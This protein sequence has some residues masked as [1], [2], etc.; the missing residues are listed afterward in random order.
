VVKVSAELGR[1]S[2]EI[3]AGLPDGF[4]AHL[5]CCAPECCGGGRGDTRCDVYALGAILWE[6]LAGR[7]RCLGLT[8]QQ[9]VALRLRGQEPALESVC[10]DV[11]PALAAVSRRAL[12]TDPRDR[13]PSMGALR[14]ELERTARLAAF[15]H[16]ATPLFGF[17][18]NH[19]YQEY[20]ALSALLEKH[21]MQDALFGER[22]LLQTGARVPPRGAAGPSLLESGLRRVPVPS[23]QLATTAALG[24]A[25]VTPDLLPAQREPPSVPP[26]LAPGF[27]SNETAVI[28]FA[29]VGALAALGFSGTGDGLLDAGRLEQVEP[30]AVVPNA[31]PPPSA[32]SARR[33]PAAATSAP[34]SPSPGGSVV[35]VEPAVAADSAHAVPARGSRKRLRSVPGN[36]APRAARGDGASDAAGSVTRTPATRST[37]TR[38]GLDEVST[39]AAGDDLR[40]LKERPPRAIDKQDPYSP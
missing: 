34:R 38:S 1:C 19:F 7:P 5:A 33:E 35:T 2:P 17:M 21:S 22:P 23:I 13:H 10:P 39:G 29:V 40:T 28:V 3:G 20:A 11:L 6:A 14:E 30:A 9:A 32:E 27:G 24:L 15:E 36:P 12:A 31:S 8:P 18:C 26:P 25:R 16:E 37:A 4:P